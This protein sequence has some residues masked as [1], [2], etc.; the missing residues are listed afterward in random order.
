M[1]IA[2]AFHSKTGSTEKTALAIKGQ[3]EKKG[4]SV[5]FLKLVPERDLKAY[6]YRKNGKELKLKKVVS[7]VK[8]FDLVVVGTPIWGF[9][10]TPIVLSYLRSLKN[11]SGKR[12]ALFATC[13]ALPGTSIQRM[14]SILTTKGARVLNS[15]TIKSIFPLDEKKLAE[16]KRFA[17]SLEEKV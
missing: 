17:D 9:S 3:L 8:K 1:N 15:L 10:P 5:T 6:Q 16:A 13:T 7:D 14:G 4:H 11:T 2:I 12:F